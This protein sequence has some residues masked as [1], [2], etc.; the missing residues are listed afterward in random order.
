MIHFHDIGLFEQVKMTFNVIQGHR[1]PHGLIENIVQVSINI[2][3][4]YDSIS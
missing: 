1:K 2:N 3:S 4:N